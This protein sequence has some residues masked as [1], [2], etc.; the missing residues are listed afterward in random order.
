M[1]SYRIGYICGGKFE[2]VAT[3]KTICPAQADG[4]MGLVVQ[5]KQ[6][7]R[8]IPYKLF[9]FLQTS[10]EMYRY[11]LYRQKYEIDPT[12]HFNGWDI[13]FYGE[14]RIILGA[15]SYIGQRSAIQSAPG[16]MVKIGIGCAISHNVRIYTTTNVA[17]QDFSL[18]RQTKTA[19]VMIED[20]VWIGANV[21]INPGV[22][23][24]TN[25]I[26][27]ANSVVTRDIAAWS[28]AGGVPARLIRMKQL[29]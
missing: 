2:R 10:H 25:S 20:N 3:A 23:I 27:G 26:V 1:A 13:T 5:L 18:P 28:I 11:G 8:F 9:Q 29:K 17:A 24:G 14:G 15:G 12:F 16:C 7:I 21:F 19:N 22:T 4:L 6:I